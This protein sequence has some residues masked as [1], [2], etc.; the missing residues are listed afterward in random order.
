[1]NC[2]WHVVELGNLALKAPL[3]A[4]RH[5]HKQRHDTFTKH[6][7]QG[8]DFGAMGAVQLLQ[9]LEAKQSEI[10]ERDREIALLR[11]AR[12]H[13]VE[14]VERFTADVRHAFHSYL[15][16]PTPIY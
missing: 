16:I 8:I 5:V 7:S 13:M 11:E 9:D 6:H 2:A 14:K 12:S 4:S 1:M 3:A 15:P 10:A